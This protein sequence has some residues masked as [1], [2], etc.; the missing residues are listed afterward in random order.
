MI[1]SRGYWN[2][3]FIL[4]E[5]RFKTPRFRHYTT[6]QNTYASLE[7]CPGAKISNNSNFFQNDE[8]TI[9]FGFQSD[10]SHPFHLCASFHLNFPEIGCIPN[11]QDFSNFEMKKMPMISKSVFFFYI[12]FFQNPKI[13]IKKN[14]LKI[15]LTYKAFESIK[16]FKIQS[17]S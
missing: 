16:N 14:I 2:V 10:I 15:D 5:I 17:F 6:L 4:S 9:V 13:F 1:A 7:L 8:P 3:T 11:V 12:S